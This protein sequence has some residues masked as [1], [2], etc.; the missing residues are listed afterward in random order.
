MHLYAVEESEDLV[1][2]RVDAEHPTAWQEGNGKQMLDHFR[3]E[4]RHVLVSV[5]MQ[6]TFLPAID[7]PVPDKLLIDWLL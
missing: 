1:K 3:A 4:G 7:K 2:V 5:G 6:L